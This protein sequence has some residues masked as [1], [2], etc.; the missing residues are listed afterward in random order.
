SAS[1]SAVV[2]QTLSCDP[3]TWTGSPTF[4]FEWLR[5]GAPIAGASSQQYTLTSADAGHSVACRV[6][7]T[8]GGGS[9]SA[10][11][12]GVAVSAPAAPVVQPPSNSVQPSLPGTGKAGDSVK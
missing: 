5:D 2:G 1:G 10:T 9:N 12:D 8:N 3:G 11:S 6:T 4:A 7:G